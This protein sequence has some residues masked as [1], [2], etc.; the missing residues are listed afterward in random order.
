[1]QGDI[2]RLDFPPP[3]G[4]DTPPSRFWEHRDQ[5]IARPSPPTVDPAIMEVAVKL[6]FDGGCRAKQG[7]GGFVAWC[8]GSVWAGKGSGLGAALPRTT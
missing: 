5:K 2:A 7:S 4:E 3:A 8:G 1:M 6:F